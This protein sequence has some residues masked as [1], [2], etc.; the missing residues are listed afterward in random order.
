MVNWEQ[1]VTLDDILG[2][3]L[4]IYMHYLEDI[5]IFSPHLEALVINI[6]FQETFNK[7]YGKFGGPSNFKSYFWNWNSITDVYALFKDVVIFIAYLE[8]LLINIYFLESFSK[9]CGTFGGL[10]N[11][12]S[13]F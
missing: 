4:M 3:Q 11:F 10:S 2:I 6:Y 1:L 8:I 12:T 9:S 7:S 5:V 13:Y